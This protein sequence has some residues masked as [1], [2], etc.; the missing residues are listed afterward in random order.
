MIN[1]GL[2][3][4]D[5]LAAGE[6][7]AAIGVNTLKLY[8]M[9]GLPTEHDDDLLELAALVKRLRG[10]LLGL[11]RARGRLTEIQL[12]VSSFVPKPWTPFQYQ[13]FAGV[14]ELRRRLQLLRQELRDCANVRL[15]AEPPERAFFQAVIARG[16][17][18][19]GAALLRMAGGDGQG[20]W[21]RQ[22]LAL[23]V[24][25]EREATR[26]RAAARA[27]PWEIVDSGIHPGFLAAEYQRALAGQGGERCRVTS[28]RRCGVCS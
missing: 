8:C 2:A 14:N 1:K 21:R 20:N 19:L 16:D 7:L 23:G 10:L 13:P 27:Y 5:I 3:E 11:G 18:R 15:G 22:L 9:I 28:C 25:P 26:E 17:R 12:S 6:A 24:D 4:A